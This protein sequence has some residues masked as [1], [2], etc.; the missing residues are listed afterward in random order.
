MEDVTR[1]ARS[2]WSDVPG[3]LRLALLISA[4]GAGLTVYGLNLGLVADAPAAGFSAMPLLAGLAVLPVVLALV[5]VFLGRPVV[6][7]GVLIGF[8]LLAPGRALMDLQLA[9]DALLVSRPEVLVPTNLAP[10][11]AGTGLWVLLAGYVA[12]AVAGLLVVGSAGAVPG[13]A[14]AEELDDGNGLP[15]TSDDYGADAYGAPADAPAGPDPAGAPG[16]AGG[17]PGGA[18]SSARSVSAAAVPASAGARWLAGASKAKRASSRRYLIGWGVVCSTVAAVGLLL[19]PFRSGNAF[20]LALDIIGSPALARTGGLV[21]IGTLVLGSMFATGTMPSA[22]AKGTT[23]GLLVG[24][25]GVTMPA[26]VAGLVVDRLDPT[27]GP[28]LALGAVGLLVVVVF[29]WPRTRV[30]H[31]EPELRLEARRL[32][33]VT[34]LLGLGTGLAALAGGFGTLLVV[35]TG[36]DRPDSFANRQLVPAGIIVGLLGAVML[37]RGAAA[38][39]RPAL[40]VAVASVLLVGAG[41]LDAALTGAGVSQAVHVGA[42][43]W[44]TGFAMMLAVAAAILAGIAGAAEREDLDLTERGVNI[45]VAVPGTAAVLF[46]F[47]AF[48][49]PAIRAPEFV[50]PGIWSEFRLSSWGLLLGLVVVIAVAVL[51]PVSRPSRAA[52]LLLGAAVVVGVHLLEFPL[53][54]GRVEQAVAA[55]GTW[56]SAAALVALVVAAV[57]AVSTRPSRR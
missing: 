13:S 32:H 38:A 9:R 47:G 36:I 48:G 26:I 27:V 20:Q 34:G 22:L 1:P 51:A 18:G 53:T 56:L 10:L 23:L 30:P 15:D 37:I 21:V 19:P 4:L 31:E 14:Y 12:A 40:A 41:T 49:L 46:A 44:F 24:V 52:A 29:V 11:S 43:T 5:A 57:V 6:A 50:A 35:E 39:V 8:G 54:S 55:Q 16:S 17:L 28:Y 45:A 7:S 25:A 42:G 33:L 3:R 2:G